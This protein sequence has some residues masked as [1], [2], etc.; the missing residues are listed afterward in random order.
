MLDTFQPARDI[1]FQF[2]KEIFPA[3]RRP[4]HPS[5]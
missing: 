5:F 4:P 1:F 2:A 3:A